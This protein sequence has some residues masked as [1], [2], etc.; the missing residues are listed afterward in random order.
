LRRR[1]EEIYVMNKGF[2]LIEIIAVLLI[3]ALAGASVFVSLL[4][5]VEGLAVARDQAAL[6]QKSRMAMARI[7]REMTTMTFCTT[8]DAHDTRY[9]FLVP[10]G[11]ASFSEQEHHLHWTGVPGEPITL[12]GTTLLDDVQDFRLE[13]L[14]GPPRTIRVSF[15]VAPANGGASMKLSNMIVPR[16]LHAG[17]GT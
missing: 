9:H 8:N 3:T 11:L 6:A 5:A 4:P 13:Y 17:G 16:N 1:H 2:S 7:S 10:S 15:S 14:A 12:Q